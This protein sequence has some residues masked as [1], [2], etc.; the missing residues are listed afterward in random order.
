M[1][2]A[3]F[4]EAVIAESDATEVVDGNHYF[5]PA[6]VAMTHLRESATTTNCPWKGDAKYYDVVVGESVAK[7]GAWC[8]PQ[9]KEAAKK[10]E[11]Y[12]AFW[13]GVTVS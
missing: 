9:T 6:S 11:G 4:H 2:K 7:D 10:I 13:N 5:P 3:T 1:T 8:Y 12:L